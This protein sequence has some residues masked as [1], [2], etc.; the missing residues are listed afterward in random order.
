VDSLGTLLFVALICATLL[1]LIALVVY[2]VASAL[3]LGVADRILGAT[4]ALLTAQWRVGG[5]LSIVTGTAIIAV[6]VWCAVNL[7][8]MFVKA[9]CLVLVPF[10]VWRL[11]RGVRILRAAR[12]TPAS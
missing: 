3:G 7:E 9:L 12:G 4:M 2:V 10:G 11:V 8:P 6:G 1:P 5:V